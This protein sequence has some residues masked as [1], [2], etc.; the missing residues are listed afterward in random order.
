[1]SY[2]SKD[3]ILK[4]E[5]LPTRD[6]EVP[7]WGGTVRVRGLSGA[8]RDLYQQSQLEIH[9]DGTAVTTLLNGRARLASLCIVD[10]DGNQLFS[11]LEVGRLGQKSAAALERINAVV[12]ELSALPGSDAEAEVEGNSEAAPSGDSGST[13][14]E[15]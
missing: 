1:M 15:S 7:E 12:S 8:N 10:E 2:L 13:S 4:A 3:D 5:D 9:P 6:V 14:P 11:E